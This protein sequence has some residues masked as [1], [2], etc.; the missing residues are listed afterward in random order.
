M[1]VASA[2][3]EPIKKELKKYYQYMGWGSMDKDGQDYA[4]YAEAAKIAREHGMGRNFV[5]DAA[6]KAFAAA[7]K[8]WV[9]P[10]AINI[11]MEYAVFNSHILLN[12]SRERAEI[13]SR[14]QMLL[15]Q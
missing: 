4:Y 8:K 13:T 6:E 9:Y 10:W 5:L 3:T 1:T 11:A 14:R 12:Y 15:M 2:I 7:M